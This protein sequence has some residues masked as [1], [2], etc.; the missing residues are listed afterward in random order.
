MIPGVD[1]RA[2]KQ[3]MKKMGMKQVDLDASTVIIVLE[4]K[5]LVFEN[6][7][8]QKIEMMGQISF[9]LTGD[10]VEESLESESIE[11]DDESIETVMSQT[12]CSKERAISALEETNG[13][14]AEAIILL[15]DE[16]EG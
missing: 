9:Q 12:N 3:A 4:D 11:I 5:K 8:V 1:P 10:F 14:I 7:S 16:R 2:M 15:S 13:D 6:P